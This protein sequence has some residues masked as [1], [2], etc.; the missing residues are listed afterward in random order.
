MRDTVEGV[1]SGASD[2]LAYARWAAFSSCLYQRHLH[3][4]A[5]DRMGRGDADRTF[6]DAAD[7]D[8]LIQKSSAMADGEVPTTTSAWVSPRMTALARR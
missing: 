8:T 2:V 1:R 4:S 5:T 7:L 3:R 6:S